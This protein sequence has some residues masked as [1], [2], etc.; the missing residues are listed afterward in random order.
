[1]KEK[2][3]G[4]KELETVLKRLNELEIE[5]ENNGWKIHQGIVFNNKTL[6]LNN[7]ALEKIKKKYNYIATDIIVVSNPKKGNK[8]YLTIDRIQN[9]TFDLEF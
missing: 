5:N 1:M 4:K 6:L 7:K 2:I 9:E 3:F 8:V